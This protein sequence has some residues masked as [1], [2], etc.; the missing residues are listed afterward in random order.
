MKHFTNLVILMG[1]SLVVGCASQAPVTSSGTGSGGE[2]VAATASAQ[3]ATAQPQSASL[4]S[5]TASVAA[6]KDDD[7]TRGYQ[8]VVVEG[9]ELFCRREA[10][11]GSRITSRVC[12]TRAELE[13]QQEAARQYIDS[14]Q[15]GA[16]AT[17][18]G[19]P[20]NMPAAGPY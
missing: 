1:A 20:A 4:T 15:R 8:R 10:A 17:G 2:G 6:Q 13:A 3:A 12:R 19:Q 18:T 7:A 16:G 14:A 9:Q 11:P 5:Q